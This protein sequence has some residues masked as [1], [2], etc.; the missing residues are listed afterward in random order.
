MKKYV[1]ISCVSKKVD[2]AALSKDL[3]TSTLFKMSYRYAVSLK[4]DAIFIL[5]AKYG[6][7]LCNDV[8]TPY[9]MTLNNMKTEEVE[10]FSHPIGKIK[11][12]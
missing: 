1:L 9:N 10:E 12:R 2:H 11:N 8:V 3:Y 4:P 5:S 7:L 6:L